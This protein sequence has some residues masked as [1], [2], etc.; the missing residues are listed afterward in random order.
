MGIVVLGC[1][2]GLSFKGFCVLSPFRP[3]FHWFHM[4]IQRVP[5][6]TQLGCVR[7]TNHCHLLLMLRVQGVTPPL[8][9][10][11]FLAHTAA[12]LPFWWFC[13]TI[14]KLNIALT[15]YGLHS[16]C[17]CW[18]LSTVTL[19]VHGCCCSFLRY[20]L[21]H[22][23][24]LNMQWRSVQTECIQKL[25]MMVNGSKY[26]RRTMNSDTSHAVLNQCCHIR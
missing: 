16:F 18:T 24:L 6:V 12:S 8:T 7:L 14:R 10:C 17:D 3:T 11:A 25:S 2:A 22:V 15:C 4:S 20:R 19:N 1:D 13:R 23:N 21:R 26:I 9:Q 5:A